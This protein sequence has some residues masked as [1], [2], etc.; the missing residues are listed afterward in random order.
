MISHSDNFAPGSADRFSTTETEVVTN[1]QVTT[2]MLLAVGLYVL[3]ALL[4]F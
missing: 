4:I 3:A 2:V 1:R